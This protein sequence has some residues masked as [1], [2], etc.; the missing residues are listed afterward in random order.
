MD[1]ITQ[2]ALGA[3]LGEMMMGKRLGNRALA[4]GALFGLLP[5]LLEVLF[6]PITDTARELSWHHAA[7]HCIAVIA[8][9]CWGIPQGLERLWKREK[10]SRKE[11]TVFLLA[12]WCAH[13]ALDICTTDGVALLWPILDKRVALNFLNPL[14]LLFSAPL[15]V[16]VIWLACLKEEKAKKSRSKKPQPLPKRHK[17]LRWGLGVMAGYA[18]LALTMKSV[19]SAGFGAD[20]TR[21][22]TKFTRKIEVPTPHNF[23]L[24]RSVVDRGDEM[25]VGY[26]SI[27]ESRETPVRWTIYP[28]G[29]SAVENV[30]AT[31]EGKTLM[32]VCDGWWLARPHAKGAWIG[33]LRQP[34]ARDWG[35]KKTMVDSRLSRSWVI[36]TEVKGD[37]LR[38]FSEQATTGDFLQR[39]GGR[40]IGRREDWEANPRLAGMRGSLPEFLAVEQ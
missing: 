4:W 2:A 14:D 33:D 39:L 20:L 22:G 27:F 18:V 28:K 26:R 35:A 1:W 7:G 38:A 23:L 12:V 34:E 25:W 21:R 36:D 32:A 17:I 3:A 9:G 10:I 19:A 13:V 40:I 29:G 24:W 5:E 37:H 15:V 31:R 6:F 30:K 16:S 8:L 11:A